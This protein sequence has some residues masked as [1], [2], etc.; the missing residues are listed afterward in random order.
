MNIPASNSKNVAN[1]VQK[2]TPSYQDNAKQNNE[3]QESSL[4]QSEISNV[5]K[6]KPNIYKKN[7]KNRNKNVFIDILKENQSETSLKRKI[8]SNN[9][10][11]II[12]ESADS[13]TT[14]NTV[15]SQAM[16]I[17]NPLFLENEQNLSPF[18]PP[19][20]QSTILEDS[21]SSVYN[22]SNESNNSNT[23]YKILKPRSRLLTH[24]YKNTKK[25]LFEN[26]FETDRS[27]N[28]IQSSVTAGEILEHSLKLSKISKAAADTMD[29]NQD[30]HIKKIKVL[31]T[32]KVDERKVS[33]DSITSNEESDIN[34]DHS[35][36]Q[37]VKS[38]FLTRLR[39]NQ[40]KN[41]FQDIF[42]ENNNVDTLIASP[43]DHVSPTSLHSM[44]KRRDDNVESTSQKSTRSSSKTQKQLVS[45]AVEGKESTKIQDTPKPQSKRLSNLSKHSSL[46]STIVQELKDNENT[47]Q[48][49]IESL[50]RTQKQSVS[51][52]A[53]T[54]ESTENQS[55]SKRHSK[56]L[57]NLSKHS[58][59]H[60][61]SKQKLED[62]ENKRQRS[63]RSSSSMQKQSVSPAAKTGES[64]KIQ[65]T[66]KRQNKR[67][68][69]LSK[70]SSLHSTI[71]QELRDIENTPQRNIK[72]LSRMQKRSVSP[73]A[74]TG[75]STKIQN[76]SKRQNKR[77]STLSKHSSLHST[78][79]Q[80]LENIE[81]TPQ[82]SIR[83]SN[84]MQKQS[85]SPAA[86]TGESTNIQSISKRQSKRLST[87][88]KHS[89]LDSTIVQ[90]LRDIENTSQRSVESLSRMQKR[91]VSPAAETGESTNIQSISKRQSK[92]LS[93]LSKHSSLDSTIVQELR[94]IENT[95][96][97]S[98]ESLSRMQKRSVSPAAETGESTKIQDTS[99]PQNKRLSTLSKHSSLHST[100]KQELED[101]ESTPQR[102]IRSSNLMQK[103]S[104]SPAAETVESTKIQ[105]ISKRQSKRL[106]TL[107]K[108]SSLD[109]TIVQELRDIENTPQR[110]IE[111][112]SRMQ[113]QSVSPAAV[114]GESTEN[115]DIS[116]RQGKS[117][118]KLGK[119]RFSRPTT[120]HK[121]RDV[122]IML[123]RNTKRLNSMQEHSLS[124]VAK[125][126]EKIKD[127]S[128]IR[129]KSLSK[130]S[131]K[132]SLD[133]TSEE[134][135]DDV[136]STS[137]K[138]TGNSSKVQAQLVAEISDKIS[139]PQKST[140]SINRIRKLSA[141]FVTE[142]DER[143]E[144][145][146]ISENQIKSSSMASKRS[147]SRFTNVRD[148]E[149]DEN[150]DHHNIRSLS[151][152]Q[153]DETEAPLTKD[154]S[155]S[156]KNRSNTLKKCSDLLMKEDMIEGLIEDSTAKQEDNVNKASK[157]FE[158]VV[159]NI[160]S[161][162]NNI[163]DKA[164]KRT[165]SFNRS[166][167]EL[168]MEKIVRK[169]KRQKKVHLNELSEDENDPVENQ[170]N[171]K[172]IFVTGG[173]NI[174]KD[175]LI[176]SSTKKSNASSNKIY[177]NLN[178][179]NEL[180]EGNDATK[181][182]DNRF[183]SNSSISANKRN[184]CT[185]NF[186]TENLSKGKESI[187]ISSRNQE[188]ENR[189]QHTDKDKNNVEKPSR[190][191][192]SHLSVS[193]GQKIEENCKEASSKPENLS[194]VIRTRINTESNA[195]KRQQ[196]IRNFLISDKALS[197]SQ[198]S[199]NKM[200]IEEINRE[201][202]KM[203]KLEIAHMKA[204]EKKYERKR[205]M[206]QKNIKEAGKGK[207]STSQKQGL[208]KPAKP[209]HKAFLVN[210]QVY[211]VRRLPRPQHW[212][213][214]QLYNYLWERM[215]PKY[216][217]ETKAISEKFIHQLSN[218]TTF[219][220]K[221]KSYLH[222][223]SELVMLMKE[224]ARLGIIRT[225]NDFYHFCHNFFP[226]SLRIKTVPMLLPGNKSNIPYDANKLHEPFFDS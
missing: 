58:S 41:P 140:R 118:S 128:K 1:V 30:E 153:N 74:E 147:F 25:N 89:S 64:T 211:K 76:T 150:S 71:V 79:K 35:A 99:R 2:V 220:S 60:S 104:V 199:K 98:V 203:K 70:H 113:K 16:S 201:L 155:N 47:A 83:S 80:G 59:L 61:T 189:S 181:K 193:K 3:I 122:K 171:T 123:Q 146:D 185:F 32:S 78:S 24:N 6:L 55:I 57:R 12:T 125:I 173:F 27:S 158:G 215:K 13:A 114:T 84:R 20:A 198:L 14:V 4:N 226:Y 222:Y 38:K 135:R 160:S 11:Q 192:T 28:K 124:P 45:F 36:V 202:E 131:K 197:A 143:T 219:I 29:E 187:S 93:T 88:S 138:N 67:L 100:S 72:S 224:M 145:D 63:I 156:R 81:S 17:Q 111:S 5:L 223:K 112:S 157:Q 176:L 218:I 169:S 107:S 142:V 94:D 184:R 139:I 31:S 165:Y 21:T 91:S 205:A 207:N 97:R 214:D 216:K 210:G 149:G 121:G 96:Q 10:A 133:S 195:S 126:D 225:R 190:A 101:I 212:V 129:S 109:S 49:S 51:S 106:S 191:S 40:K 73:A 148:L 87:L 69:T 136:E 221:S 137:Q 42:E 53:E 152:M 174:S 50:S 182:L 102:S 56:R 68:S 19:K 34:R 62:I 208:T 65:N 116:K 44:S 18:P 179:L 120:E 127:F 144:T 161:R 188:I 177:G 132:L 110:S 95:P 43:S 86:E 39:K 108:H 164:R 206:L 166:D 77:L 154:I 82:R 66:S 163:F 217:L 209:I 75:E 130:V 183:A 54:S 204:N 151:R 90:E 15:L 9:A 115:Q 172:K 48:R 92:R 134:E 119:Y 105:S 175:Q 46:H 37:R 85:V 186:E 103:Q 170:E 162:Q 167:S 159:K 194:S 178:S 7:Y 168:E 200:K 33:E 26:V 117:S 213:T 23:I 8:S 180:V 52:A 141:S 196:S 22:S